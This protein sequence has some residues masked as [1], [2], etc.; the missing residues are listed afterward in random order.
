M[1]NF[2]DVTVGQKLRTFSETLYT[3]R[4]EAVR[5]L[6]LIA[7]Q[8]IALGPNMR[9]LDTSQRSRS[10]VDLDF[11]LFISTS[12]NV[13]RSDSE[14]GGDQWE[15]VR[16]MDEDNVG[17]ILNKLEYDPNFDNGNLIELLDTSSDG[18]FFRAKLM[19]DAKVL[20]FSAAIASYVP[21]LSSVDLN[22]PTALEV[23]E[24][25]VTPSSFN[26]LISLASS[27]LSTV[28]LNIQITGEGVLSSTLAFTLFAIGGIISKVAEQGYSNMHV[29]T[30]YI[31]DQVIKY[32]N[33]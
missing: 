19:E 3:D 31:R 1:L 18:S 9:L 14:V 16:V 30:S 2:L 13:R 26:A 6:L 10:R 27:L 20:F 22:L 4:S 24:L 17:Q 23:K 21:L 15:T 11:P 28:D 7:A 12:T 32:D 29:A 33:K 5:N 8:K 25:L